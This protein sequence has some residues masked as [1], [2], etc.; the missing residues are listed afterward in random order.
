MLKD[1]PLNHNEG[2][3]PSFL[4]KNDKKLASYTEIHGPIKDEFKSKILI[5]TDDHIQLIFELFCKEFDC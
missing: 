4:I 5:S 2:D 1:Y 3:I